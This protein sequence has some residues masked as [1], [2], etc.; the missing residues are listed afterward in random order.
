MYKTSPPYASVIRQYMQRQIL[1][2]H[3]YVSRGEVQVSFLLLLLAVTLEFKPCHYTL[4]SAEVVNDS[5][6][7]RPDGQIT[8][9][10]FLE[11]WLFHTDLF[12]CHYHINLQLNH[13]LMRQISNWWIDIINRVWLLKPRVFLC[14]HVAEW[15]QVSLMICTCPYSTHMHV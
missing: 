1:D 8:F 12:L 15:R 14:F 11:I 5:A 13:A 10:R 6:I 4:P 7:V 9:R 2:L 3:W